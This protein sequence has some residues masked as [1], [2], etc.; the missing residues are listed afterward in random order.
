MNN[1]SLTDKCYSYAWPSTSTLL[2]IHGRR[3]GIILL[4]CTRPGR[5]LVAADLLLPLLQ[6]LGSKQLTTLTNFKN[7]TSLKV[8]V[9]NVSSIKSG[10][11]CFS[12]ANMWVLRKKCSW[13]HA[14]VEVYIWWHLWET[15]WNNPQEQGMHKAYKLFTRKK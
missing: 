8:S 12:K 13:T 7:G 10:I 4:F 6:F 11:M 2:P 14:F 15:H 3:I 9:Q 5:T 1:F